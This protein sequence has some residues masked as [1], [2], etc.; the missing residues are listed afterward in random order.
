[1]L[2]LRFAFLTAAEQDRREIGVLKAIGV[3]AG[4]TKST[5]L[6]K[7][8]VLA[9]LA[10]LLGLLVGRLLIP[11]LTSSI[12]RYMGSVPSVWDWAAPALAAVAVFAILVGFVA[13]LLRRFDRISAVEALGSGPAGRPVPGWFRPRLHRS[14][15]PLNFTLGAMDVA[16]RLP[17]Y[18][19]LVGVFAVST[20]IMVVPI[21]SAATANAPDFIRYMG[22]GPVDLRIDLR[23]SGGE[24]APAFDAAVAQLRSD[25]QVAAIA[26][27]VTTRQATVD[28]DG[29]EASLYVENGDHAALP[30]TYADGRAPATDW[31]IALSLLAL[32]Q[33]GLQVG[34]KLPIETGGQWRELLVVGS[35]QD[36]TNGGR[37]AKGMLDTVGEEVM[38]YVV[39]VDLA[40]GADVAAKAS[41]LSSELAPATVADI[42]QWRSQT[43]GP[44]AGQLGGAAAVAA[45][46]AVLL[47]VVMTALFTRMLLARDAAPIAVQRALG[48]GE[49]GI[50]TQY[51]TR[52]LLVLLLGVVVGAVAANTVG[53]GVFNLMFEAM[54]GGLET[55][56]QGTSRIAFD[57]NPLLTMLA[58]P[59][60]LLTAVAL[61]ASGAL[62]RGNAQ[63]ISTLTIE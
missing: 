44:I 2:C 60:V 41:Q 16:G 25:P 38:W 57:V 9:G 55:L 5:Y 35:Y 3:P 46:A 43:L 42:A 40:A 59:L 31:E 7:Y 6:V 4:E 61:A 37:T 29:N 18:L 20:F 27:M 15:L 63:T 32:N 11:V 58:L 54:F 13:V 10:T 34:D 28:K 1:M 12:T 49:A 50:R 51:L 62:H 39:G 22:T 8:A 24:T 33:A 47:A 45:V 17:T 23:Q 14:R 52:I 21:S 53:E 19:L 26:P 48:T 56:G 36:I 30:V